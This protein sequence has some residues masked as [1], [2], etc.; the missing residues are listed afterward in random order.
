MI[1]FEVRCR[2]RVSRART[3]ILRTPH[4]EVRTPT[5]VPVATLGA[6]KS[7]TWEQVHSTATQLLI[8]NTF[9]L[10]LRPGERVVREAGGLNS[11]TG[12]NK[13]FMTDSGGFQVF[14]LGFGR[15]WQVG[16][17]LKSSGSGLEKRGPIS[18]HSQPKNV[19]ITPEGVYFNSPL[20]G[21][22]LFIGPKES[23]AIQQALGADIIFAFDECTAPLC[24]EEYIKQALERTHRWAQICLETKTSEQALF[25]IVQ[26]SRFQDLRENSA[27]FIN[28]L[29]FDGFGVGGEFG[30]EKMGMWNVLN[31]TIPYLD[32]H[33][34]RHL[35]GIGYLEDMRGV[36]E[37]GIDLFDC[38]VPTRLARHGVAF[39]GQGK[40]NLSQ[41][42]FLT[43]TEP[44]DAMCECLTCQKYRRNF[45]SHLVRARELTAHAL[46]T[47]HNLSFFNKR[48]ADLRQHIE[49]GNL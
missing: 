16:K 27:K 48:V 23:M 41:P 6:V 22:K 33:K 26:G 2:S 5:L 40:I 15:D 4:G 32:D 38:T 28:S 49:D 30:S 42:T 21:R 9:H 39:T 47:I 44:L 29:P 46:L 37:H 8:A 43:D 45:L 34:P 18:S 7:L 17:V 13:P 3:G 1:E 14:S 31:W 11:F 24:T 35:L 19:K 20:D 10:H 36:I 25:G 12:W